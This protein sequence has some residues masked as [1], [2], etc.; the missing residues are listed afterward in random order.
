[1]KAASRTKLACAMAVCVSL[2]PIVAAEER[3]PLNRIV[4]VIEDEAITELELAY[5][6]DRAV[7]MLNQQNLEIPDRRILARQVL[8]QITIRQLQLQEAKKRNV[9]TDDLALDRVIEA[10]AESKDLSLDAFEQSFRNSGEDYQ[11]FR[12]NAREELT[13]RSLI[14]H[15]VIDQI[16]VSEKEIEDELA[17]NATGETGAEYHFVQIRVVPHSPD[18]EAAAKNR[19]LRIRKQ[20]HA[21]SFP[22]LSTF[23]EQFSRLWEAEAEK[24]AVTD[25]T[26][27]VKDLRWRRIEDLPEPVSRRIDSLRSDNVSPVISGGDG[28]YLFQRLASHNDNQVMMQRQ[29]RVRHILMPT[30]LIDSDDKVRKQ[31]IAIKRKLEDGADFAKFACTYSRDPLSSTRGGDLGWSDL[32]GFVP[33]F[34]EAARRAYSTGTLVGPFKTEYGWHLLEVTDNREENVAD[35]TLRQQAAATIRQRKSEESIRLWLL[36]LREKSRVEIRI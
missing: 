32:Q 36:G 17:S 23:D 26:Y 35:E 24:D 16:Q 12:R 30:S 21:R 29:Y 3:R 2:A 10:M 22:S 20:L 7:R 9:T 19:L 5:S 31:L 33:E 27:H 34:V 15:E 25:L 4:A 11:A 13:I 8:Q 14:Q 28:L 6:I 1:M 18:T